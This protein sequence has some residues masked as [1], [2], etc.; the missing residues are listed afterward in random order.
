VTC[1]GDPVRLVGELRPWDLICG[2]VD[3]VWATARNIGVGEPVM[4]CFDAVR[5]RDGRDGVFRTVFLAGEL[6][7]SRPGVFGGTWGGV[8]GAAA[9][10]TTGAGASGAGVA[11]SSSSA[12]PVVGVL[13]P[14]GE[15]IGERGRVGLKVVHSGRA[16]LIGHCGTGDR[17]PPSKDGPDTQ[18]IIGSPMMLFLQFSSGKLLDLS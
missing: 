8:S 3:G 13:L 16:T 10:M 15:K 11:A 7:C 1:F 17:M 6:E 4:S 5:S 14:G 2:L 18:V 12:N 9:A